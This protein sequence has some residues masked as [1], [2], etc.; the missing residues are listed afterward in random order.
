MTGETAGRVPYREDQ[1]VAHAI[2]ESGEQGAAVSD[3]SRIECEEES[4]DMVDKIIRRKASL[5]GLV[6]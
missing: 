5:A 2:E 6:D 3:L 4:Q 1:A